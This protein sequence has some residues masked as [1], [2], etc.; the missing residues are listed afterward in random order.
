[1]EIS[2]QRPTQLSTLISRAPK[3]ASFFPKFQKWQILQIHRFYRP[4]Y[5]NPIFNVPRHAQSFRKTRYKL[6]K[7][8]YFWFLAPKKFFFRKIGL[9]SNHLWKKTALYDTII[10]MNYWT[11]KI[12]PKTKKILWEPTFGKRFDLWMAISWER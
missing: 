7:T 8:T 1:M 5:S 2:F 6:I 4:H 12:T 11:L 9:I 3:L 10:R